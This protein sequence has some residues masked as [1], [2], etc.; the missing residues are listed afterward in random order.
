M[1][2]SKLQPP[3]SREIPTI[4]FQD[5][6]IRARRSVPATLGLAYDGAHGVTRPTS[7]M[8][9]AWCFSGCWSLEFGGLR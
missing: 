3:S 1:K 8:F 6:V 4:N 9:S 7:L 2:I 5:V